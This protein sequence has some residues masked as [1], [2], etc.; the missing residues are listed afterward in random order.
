MYFNQLKKWL[1]IICLWITFPLFAQQEVALPK[2]IFGI[3]NLSELQMKTYEKDTSAK[4]VVLY[5]YAEV[6]FDDRNSEIIIV[7]EIHQ[8]IKILSKSAYDLATVKLNFLDLNSNSEDISDLKGFTHN[9]VNGQIVSEKLTKKD[10]IKTRESDNYSSIR[11]TLP[12]VKEGSVIE[13]IYTKTTPFSISTNPPVWYFQREI[14]VVWSIIKAT[15]PD[16]FTYKTIF[17]GYCPMT[18]NS[19]NQTTCKILNQS[20]RCNETVYAI[21]DVPV[22]HSENYITTIKDYTASM[23]W[24]LS[25]VAIPSIVYKNFSLSWADLNDQLL[26]D[27]KFGKSIQSQKGLKDVVDKIKKEHSD[28]LSTA[29]AVFEYIQSTYKWNELTSIYTTDFKK[30]NE[31]KEG[32]SGD[33]NLTLV[34][35]LRQSGVDAY[36]FIL[37]TRSNGRIFEHYAVQKRFNYVVAIVNI[38]NKDYYIDAT[39]KQLKF[40]ML[41]ERCLNHLGFKVAEKT[42]GIKNIVAQERG[43]TY[44]K[45]VMKIDAERNMKGNILHSKGGYDALNMRKEIDETSE[46]KFKER[47]VK[48]HPN[49]IINNI[50]LN[51]VKTLDKSFD[52]KYDVSIADA[53]QGSEDIIYLN[54][55]LEYGMDTPPFKTTNRVFPVDF[56]YPFDIVFNAEYEIPDGFTTSELPKPSNI[57]LPNSDIKYTFICEQKANKI[58]INTRLTIKKD[59]FQATEYIGLKEFYDTV[60]AKQQEQIVL[61]KI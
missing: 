60:F 34:S 24:E 28:T 36:P 14:P 15:I 27:H 33:I 25:V 55:Y 29:K 6:K 37:S 56:A 45:I 48:D 46:Q 17:S 38:G 11:F 57:V 12:N 53:L 9:L 5:D 50:S 40:G 52:L 8:K 59:V 54:P 13:Y 21:K 30:I 16:Y 42:W 19:Q 1:P 31:K 3:P 7:T 47:V 2:V 51:N 61:K 43:T 4:A 58:I 20:T 22:I 39:E 26:D 35:L 44:T 49:W 18:I 10:I 41:P 23:D 32:D